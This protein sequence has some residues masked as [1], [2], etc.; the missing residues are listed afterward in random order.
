MH[1]GCILSALNEGRSGKEE[2][3]AELESGLV[4]KDG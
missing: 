3:Q 2:G 1:L 4:S